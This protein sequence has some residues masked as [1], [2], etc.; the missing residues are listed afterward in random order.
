[1]TD[2]RATGSPRT[3]PVLLFDGECG[4]CT[5]IVEEAT[6]RLAADVDYLPFQTAPLVSYGV[7]TAEARHSLQWVAVDGRIGHGSDA[8][9]RLLIASGGAWP[10]LG[11]LLLAPP[12]SFVAAGCYWL[13]ARF[14][15]HIPLPPRHHPVQPSGK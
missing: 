7:S 2:Q 13:I 14:R 11:R 4:F 15:G 1:M 6:Q 10:R 3:R 12:F 5:R 9:A 8:V